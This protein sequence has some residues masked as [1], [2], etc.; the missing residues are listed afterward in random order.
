[1]S[2]SEQPVVIPDRALFKASEVC[3]L[4]KVQP[5][6]LR[7]WEAEFKELGVAKAGSSTRVYRR[8]DVERVLRIKRMLLVEGLTLA[9][10]R[11]K[12]EDEAEAEL[13]LLA[14]EH[15]HVQGAAVPNGSPAL[16][17][18][19]RASITNVKR[20]LRSLLDLL[21]APVG[22]GAARSQKVLEF[23]PHSGEQASSASASETGAAER[24]SAVRARTAAGSG[25]SKGTSRRAKASS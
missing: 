4:A 25:R 6:V 13:P 22:G 2:D 16:S 7:S 21:D 1:M 23:A 20:D 19:A 10:V 9:G 24:A 11:R 14:A 15:L 18:E 17:D 5:Y 8:V 3:D 12:L